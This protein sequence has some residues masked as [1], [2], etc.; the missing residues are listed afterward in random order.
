MELDLL[1]GFTG[2]TVIDPNQITVVNEILRVSQRDY[3][4]ARA[5]LY[6]D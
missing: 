6:W 3:A 2:K 1:N 4:D 5:F